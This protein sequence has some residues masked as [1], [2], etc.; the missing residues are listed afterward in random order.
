MI[1][2]FLLA[3]ILISGLLIFIFTTFLIWNKPVLI[4]YLQL[5]FCYFSR[6]LV[7]QIGLP[8]PL[9]YLSD[10]LTM[11]LLLQI[12]LHFTKTKNLNIRKPLLFFVIYAAVAVISTVYN[13]S[14]LLFFFWGMRLNFR[15]FIFFFACVIFLRKDDIDK[16]IKFQL[17]LLPVNMAIIL[18]QYFVQGLRFDFLGGLFGNQ[19]S[20]NSELN[21]YMFLMATITI[22]FYAI[23]K[24]NLFLFT[25]NIA[26]V[27]LTAALSELKILYVV[28]PFIVFVAFIFYFP[29]TRIIKAGFIIVLLLISSFSILLI[30]YPHWRVQLSTIEDII[31]NTAKTE[32]NHAFSLSRMTAGPYLFQNVL[33]I[34]SQRLLGIGFGNAGNF[35]NFESSFFI[36]YGMLNYDIFHYAYILA[37]IGIIGLAAYCIFFM[38]ISYESIRI[39]RIINYESGFYCCISF[40]VS[41]LVL[42]FIVY[43]PSMYMDG[44]F[45]FYFPLTFPFI[46]EK[47]LNEGNLILKY[48][49]EN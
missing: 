46:I 27:S 28:I 35:L 40:I 22:V 37:E 7:H 25:I 36:R 32:Y 3:G 8:D 5:G 29:N 43:H 44:A 18:F 49:T 42:V 31:F 16:L 39:K 48:N 24:I 26:M 1:T 20:C 41:L 45:I 34:P 4:I 23:K 47:E 6:F 14:S 21:L 15:F 19:E 17:Y 2:N 11:I 33:T 30:V 38:S 12:F 9:K 13:R 10:Y